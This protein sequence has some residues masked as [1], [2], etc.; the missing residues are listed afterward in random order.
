M[1]RRVSRRNYP[2]RGYKK[3]TT[4]KRQAFGNFASAMQQRD[5]TNVVISMQED[6]SINV[7]VGANEGTMLRNVTALMTSTQYFHNYMGMYDQFKLNA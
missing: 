6:V 3:R 5:S 7:P 1:Q 2:R 4:L